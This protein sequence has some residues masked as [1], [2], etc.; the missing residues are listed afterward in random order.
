MKS[1]PRSK[2][3]I[4]FGNKTIE[5]INL[6]RIFNNPLV[7]VHFDTPT[8]GNSLMNQISCNIFLINSLI[9]LMQW[10]SWIIPLFCPVSVQPLYSIIGNFKTINNDKLHKPF[11]KGPKYHENKTADYQKAKEKMI[12]GIQA[13]IQL[14]CNMMLLNRHFLNG[15]KL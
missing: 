9:I 7:K 11:F 1:P 14:W 12:I 15:K 4:F 2:H 10:H 3:T 13:C 5:K 6:Y 8:V